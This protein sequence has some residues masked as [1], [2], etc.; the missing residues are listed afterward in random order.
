MS[1][2]KTKKATNTKKAK[3]VVQKKNL[4]TGKNA[5]R[6]TSKLLIYPE[7]TMPEH[8]NEKDHKNLKRFYELFIQGKFDVA[9]NFISAT[10]TIVREQIPSDIWIKTGG[11]LTKK[12]EEQL[13]NTTKKCKTAPS[14][15]VCPEKEEL[16]GKEENQPQKPPKKETT[17]DFSAFIIKDD[18]LQPFSTEDFNANN[19]EHSKP[20]EKKF[21]GEKELEQLVLTNSKVLFGRQALLIKDNKKVKDEY[22]PDKFLF[23]FRDTE[24]PRF[25]IIETIFSVQ[26][27][28]YFYARLTHFFALFK[29]QSRQTGFHER[30]CEIIDANKEQKDEL[31]ALIGND[32]EIAE[33]LSTMIEKKPV[34]LLIMDN[35]RSDLPLLQETYTDTW[36]KMLKSVVLKKYSSSGNTIYTMRPDFADILKNEKAKVD[37][38]KSTEEDHLNCVP[39]NIRDIYKEIKTALLKADSSIEFNP[40][41]IYI[42]LRKNKNI[43]FFHL[44]KKISLVVMNPEDDT[45]MHIEHHEIKSLPTSVQKFWNGPS[46]TIIIENAINLD[47]VINLLKKMIAKA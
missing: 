23:D 16:T 7:W 17:A 15:P 42:S 21:H 41:K 18:I 25:Y 3:A 32:R 11:K 5:K 34:I 33:F 35:L 12:G 44:R 39:E 27:F 29:T 2:T 30:L 20:V 45:S 28:G 43:A 37:I 9:L 8:L 1:K 24:K 26:N 10:D 31:Q 6:K 40:K 19:D 38:I 47:E 22:F 4:K 13:K 46:C 14:K 36:G